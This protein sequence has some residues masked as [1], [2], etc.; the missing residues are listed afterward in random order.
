MTQILL[1]ALV[2]IFAVM[3]LGYFAGWI[4]DID[5][6][7]VAELNALVMDFAVPAALFVATASTS[8]ATLLTHWPVLLA[9]L[10]P[11][12]ALYI[13]AYWIQ[14]RLFGLMPAPASVQALTI[15]FPNCAAVGLPLIAAVFGASQIIDV[16]LAIAAGAIILSPLTLALLEMN[17][18]VQAGQGKCHQILNAFGKSMLKPVVLA[19]IIGMGFSLIGISLPGFVNGALKLIGQASGGVALFLTGLILSSQRLLLN[20][21]VLSSTML[22]NIVQL[23]LA[24]GLVMVLPMSHDQV[25][26]VLLLMALPAGFFGVL[27]GLRYGVETRETGSTL[28]VSSLLSAIT[29]AIVLILTARP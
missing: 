10:V 13:V 28:I 25:R 3:A 12:V 8:R 19:P 11:M 15:A 14:R 17:K 2:P 27:F 9:L 7:H 22:K 4:R 16:A 26:A 20:R 18:P 23:L 29:L 1:G 6:H 21:N 5:N 24:L